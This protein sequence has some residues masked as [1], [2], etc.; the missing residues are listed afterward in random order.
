[1][2]QPSSPRLTKSTNQ[3]CLGEYIM[4]PGENALLR[5]LDVAPRRTIKIGRLEGRYAGTTFT[6][7]Q[8]LGR[9]WEIIPPEEARTRLE[10]SEMPA[11]SA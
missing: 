6:A 8:Q 3:L 7:G 1:M 11:L 9:R 4:Q 5:V 2:P 10:E